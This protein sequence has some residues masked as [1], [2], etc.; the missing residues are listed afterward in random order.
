MRAS[1]TALSRLLLRL[2]T[3]G[4]GQKLLSAVVA[5]KVERLAIALGVD[6]GGVVHGHS[7]DGVFGH[8]FRFIPGVASFLVVVLT[9]C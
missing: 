1:S 5:A 6:R 2:R 7:A 4:L 8:G 3:G 9:V